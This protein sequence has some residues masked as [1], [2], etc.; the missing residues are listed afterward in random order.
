MSAVKSSAADAFIERLPKDV[1]FFLVHGPDEGLAH[2]RTKRLIR[3][4]LG[5][6]VD[7]LRLVRLDG[8]AVARDPGILSDEA[9]AI[10]MFGGA[11]AIWIDA[12]GRDF[13]SALEAVMADPPRGC[14]IVVKASQ[15]KKG[16]PLRTLFESSRH[17][18]AIECFGDELGTLSALIN[19]E[20]RAEGQNIT[21]EASAALL[22]L[23]GED[24]S[25]SKQEL[26]KLM[27]YTIDKSRVEVE[28]VE[29]IVSN[30][31]PPRL[32]ELIDAALSGKVQDATASAAAYFGEGG[33]CDQ[34]LARL[35]ARLGLLYRLRLE[36]D[37]GRS[38][39]LAWQTLSAR[40]SPRSRQAMGEAAGHWTSH[41]LGERL[42]AL[43]EAAARIRSSPRLAETLT[44]RALLAI[45][46]RA[47]PART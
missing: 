6:G 31:S 8:D 13:S 40:A 33:D 21:A 18:A 14:S 10:A 26:A 45:A 2:E 20:A 16:S 1:V 28:D 34:L 17:A 46:A 27:I 44:A 23:L 37:Q 29:A 42:E 47:R 9:Y 30:V 39:N 24:R 11:R 35:A 41:A 4:R 19:Q 36:M 25:T 7:P 38:F 43:R 32:D 22:E 3:T 5:D 12:Q 15:Q